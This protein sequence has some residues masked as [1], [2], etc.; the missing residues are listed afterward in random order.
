M[1]KLPDD[2]E[3]QNFSF[4]YLLKNIGQKIIHCDHNG[5]QDIYEG[6]KGPLHD[7]TVKLASRYGQERPEAH[8]TE[9]IAK[10]SDQADRLGAE[11]LDL[12]LQEIQMKQRKIA[13]QTSK[14][15]LQLKHLKS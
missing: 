8:R 1:R 10:P 15:Q 3:D 5:L 12:E 13:I 9:S 7:M 2:Y 4:G 6:I 11:M 14:I